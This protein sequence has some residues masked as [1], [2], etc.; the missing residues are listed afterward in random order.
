[1]EVPRVLVAGRILNASPFDPE[2]FH[3]VRS[4][5]EVRREIRWQ[6]A[7]GVD[8]VKLYSSMP[9]ELVRVAVEEAHA[10]RLPVIGHLQRTSWRQA[11]ELG[12]DH[13]AHGASWSPDLLSP[14][15]RGGYQQDL[16]GRVYWLQHLDLDGAE[17]RSTLD[18]L[19][20]RAVVVDPTLIA[21]HT[22]FFGDDP[23]W[24]D[25][26]DNALVAPALVAGWRVGSFTR[27]WTPEQYAAARSA[28]PKM[29]AL[30]GRMHQRG[31]RLVVGT[32]TPTP[33]I[34]PGTS[35]HQ[36]LALLHDAGIAPAAILRMATGDAARA[37]GL[38]DEVGTIRPGLRADLVVLAGNPLRSLEHTRAIRLVM[39]AGHVRYQGGTPHGT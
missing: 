28:W 13:L 14:A 38:A 37:L 10:H 26:P 1:V 31:V 23:R 18:E 2:P 11:A 27:D 9:P 33:W 32:D 24:L 22:K 5:D 20:R 36:E 16:F 29:L 35:F 4:A 12:V 19:V 7:A 15:A 25:S 6:A 17:L 8:F 39:Q 3:P 34:V 30:V 21:Y